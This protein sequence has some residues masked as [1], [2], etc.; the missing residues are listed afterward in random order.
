MRSQQESKRTARL[1]RQ[2]GRM[3]TL[4]DIL[5]KH[6]T[7]TE[8][9]PHL[10]RFCLSMVFS[11]G[12]FFLLSRVFF[13]SFGCEHFTVLHHPP[14]PFFF[15]CVFGKILDAHTSPGAWLLVLERSCL[16]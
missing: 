3:V 13:L 5:I 1:R 9:I 15:F 4:E 16:C 11:G 2:H 10:R 14:L 6:V 12:V 8:A 7:I